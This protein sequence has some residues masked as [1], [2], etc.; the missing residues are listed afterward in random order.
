MTQ[1][2]KDVNLLDNKKGD[3][4]A[5][6]AWS[7]QKAVGPA[8]K[9]VPGRM[10]DLHKNDSQCFG[11]RMTSKPQQCA[12]SASCKASTELKPRMDHNVESIHNSRLANLLAEMK[13]ILMLLGTI[14]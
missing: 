10:D 5:I 7:Q 9:T 13:H 8:E 1:K 6:G 3:L 2:W 11:T 4:Q 14:V 12:C